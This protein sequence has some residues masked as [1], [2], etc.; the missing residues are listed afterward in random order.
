MIRSLVLPVLDYAAVLHP[1]VTHTE[2]APINRVEK[3]A[4]LFIL[5]LNVTNS[6]PSCHS[7]AHELGL[8]MWQLRWQKQAISYG[9]NLTSKHPNSWP[10]AG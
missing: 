9:L 5:G 4:F 10:S 6:L 8:L 7:I 2:A 3:R 1:L